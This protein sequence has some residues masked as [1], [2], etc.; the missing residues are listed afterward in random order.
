M[1]ERGNRA[2]GPHVSPTPLRFALVGAGGIAGGYEVALRHVSDARVV[3][4]VDVSPQAATA[5][6]AKIGCPSHPTLEA[7]LRS[8]AIDATLVCT[9]P[10]THAEVCLT[11][12]AAGIPVLCEKPLSVAPEPALR[13]VQAAADAG[14]LLAMASKFRFVQDVSRA[15]EMLAD[16][17]IGTP[18]LFE[19]T[20]SSMIDMSSRWN[21]DALVSGGGVIIDNGSH[22]V[23]LTRFLFGLI[24]EMTAFEAK[25]LQALEVE[26]TAQMLVR[27]ESGATGRIQLSWSLDQHLDTY[28]SVYGTSGVICLGWKGSW[29]R[30]TAEPDWTSFG[31]GYD[32]VDALTRQMESFCSSVLGRAPYPLSGHDA[33]ASVDA[34]AAAYASLE[35]GQ[36]I[37]VPVRTA[38][39]V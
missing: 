31:T 39:R 29:Y 10:A 11:S 26:D 17:L 19:N 30:R 32:K 22:S 38:P 20:F 13:M 18:V 14:V 8:T 27:T 12:M 2:A 35:R 24:T 9:P 16:G 6:A 37:E 33:L 25:R 5:L 34:I 1:P 15:S 23:D 36:R 21:S 7:A 4:V 3:S 28:L